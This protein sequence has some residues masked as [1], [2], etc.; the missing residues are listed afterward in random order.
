MCLWEAWCLQGHSAQ[1]PPRQLSLG[2]SQPQSSSWADGTRALHSSAQHSADRFSQERLRCPHLC[3]HPL[4]ASLLCLPFVSIRTR[5][6]G[7]RA[8]PDSSHKDICKD[9]FSK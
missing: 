2:A 1:A 6:T 3:P 5:D 9:P 8:H 7:F 4:V